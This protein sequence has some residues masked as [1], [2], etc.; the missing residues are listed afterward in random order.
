MRYFN[1]ISAVD[2][3]DEWKRTIIELRG[4]HPTEDSEFLLYKMVEDI[5]QIN[6][7]MKKYKI[8]MLEMIHVLDL[9]L[10]KEHHEG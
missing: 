2:S 9:N 8:R 7:G 4:P 3:L 1:T 6:E 10:M 5:I